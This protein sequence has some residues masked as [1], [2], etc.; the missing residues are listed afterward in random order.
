[1]YIY[2]V[3]CVVSCYLMKKSLLPL[4]YCSLPVEHMFKKI[5]LLYITDAL[6]SV[7]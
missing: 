6:K 4:Y 7:Q 5:L 1:M 3:F 2:I